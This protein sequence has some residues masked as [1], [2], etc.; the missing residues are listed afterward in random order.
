MNTTKKL[1]MVY[2]NGLTAECT[3]DIGSR[4]NSTVLVFSRIQIRKRLNMDYG[5]MVKE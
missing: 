1:A 3:R 5:K 2:I 4:E